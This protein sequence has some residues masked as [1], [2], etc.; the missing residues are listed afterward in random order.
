MMSLVAAAIVEAQAQR[1]GRAEEEEPFLLVPPPAAVEEEPQAGSSSPVTKKKAFDNHEPESPVEFL[2][3]EP[4]VPPP[5]KTISEQLL[6][7]FP[8]ILEI[9]EVKPAPKSVNRPGSVILPEDGPAPVTVNFGQRLIL[10]HV[11]DLHTT[12]NGWLQGY[13]DLTN[14][15]LDAMVFRV[16][17]F[18]TLQYDISAGKP[19]DKSFIVEL[20]VLP[21]NAYRYKVRPEYG[22]IGALEMMTVIVQTDPSKH[23]KELRSLNADRIIVQGAKAPKSK[24]SRAQMFKF[25]K[26]I[27]N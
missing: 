8:E 22:A 2:D 17:F 6:D 20:Q 7:I 15:S 25:W 11:M 10:D 14:L 23:D 3:F 26:V 5:R 19:I 18:L 12:P 4:Y 21:S 1:S 24:L 13:L 27:R 16:R 9:P